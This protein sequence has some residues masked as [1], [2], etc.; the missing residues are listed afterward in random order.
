MNLAMPADVRFTGPQRKGEMMIK[1]RLFKIRSLGDL[2]P[3]IIRLR[4]EK[5]LSDSIR[6]RIVRAGQACGLLDASGKPTSKY[7]A[8]M[9]DEAEK[10][11]RELTGHTKQA[12]GLCA[13]G[14]GRMV[15]GRA[16]TATEGCR[17]RLSRM[18]A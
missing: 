4:Y 11:A 5:G 6:G 7:F 9:N 13:C 8:L 1:G 15:R 3:M 14:C 2:V 16:K 17:K 18:A 10:L 12:A